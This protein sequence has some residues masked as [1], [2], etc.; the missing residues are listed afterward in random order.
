MAD[1]EQPVTPLAAS[2]PSL[3]PQAAGSS[4]GSATETP[5]G[6][7]KANP[8][9]IE[10]PAKKMRDAANQALYVDEQTRG[11]NVV[12]RAVMGQEMADATGAAAVDDLDEMHK[13]AGE[14]KSRFDADEKAHKDLYSKLEKAAQPHD[15]WSDKGFFDKALAVIAS[16]LLTYATGK[17]VNVVKDLADAD[18]AKQKGQ[19]DNLMSLA[20]AQGANSEQL[21]KV[22]DKAHSY[23]QGTQ[24][25]KYKKIAAEFAKQAAMATTVEAKAEAQ[26][27]VDQFTKLAADEELKYQKERRVK[28]SKAATQAMKPAATAKQD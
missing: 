12:N 15:Y 22:W 4:S 8:L 26:R 23:L 3:T 9:G 1:Y 19:L 25:L 24:A 14:Y 20:S 27:G 28:S 18:H 11:E 5:L 17:Q 2:F 16:G 7:T 10:A 13:F 6:A 21:Q